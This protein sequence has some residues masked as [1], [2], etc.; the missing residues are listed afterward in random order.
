M[1]EDND[2]NKRGRVMV[3]EE[4]FEPCEEPQFMVPEFLKP[5]VEDWTG[6]VIAG[7][8]GE[9]VQ[10]GMEKEMKHMGAFDVFEEVDADVAI[11]KE[12]ISLG[13]V[14]KPK[15]DE[16]RC[17]LVARQYAWMEKR[18]DT[19][20]ATPSSVSLRCVLAVAA[21]ENRFVQVA[22]FTTAFLNAPLSEEIYGKP[23]AGFLPAGRLWRLE[24]AVRAQASTVGVP[25]VLDQ[26]L[27]QHGLRA[28]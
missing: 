15:G 19:F 1:E 9:L 16:I 12:V 10:R 26:D 5:D 4:H 3:L 8:P 11:G 13:W 27:E 17:R 18:D 24:K 6:H 20:A 23:P 28:E 22:D 14:Y 2:P 25:G 21:M 7:Y